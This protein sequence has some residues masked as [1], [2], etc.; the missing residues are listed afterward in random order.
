MHGGDVK[1]LIRNL[2]RGAAAVVA[3]VAAR[4]PAQNSEGQRY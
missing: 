2:V 1:H 3:A 4:R